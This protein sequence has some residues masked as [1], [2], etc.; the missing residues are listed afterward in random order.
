MSDNEKKE[1]L[2]ILRRLGTGCFKSWQRPVI[3]LKA[4][5]IQA[6]VG[7]PTRNVG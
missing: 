3:S 2:N 4:S 5:L 6:G 1:L 7:V